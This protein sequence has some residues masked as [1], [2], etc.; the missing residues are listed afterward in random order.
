M[1]A[2][3]VISTHLGGAEKSLLDLLDGLKHQD[4]KILA[5]VPK[6]QGPLITRLNELGVRHVVLNLPSWYLKVSRKKMIYTL[7][8]CPFLFLY[9]IFY[10]VKIH[11]LCKKET[12]T[13]VHTT[14]LKYHLLF[15]LYGRLN[16]SVHIIIH[17][18]DIVKNSLLRR[19][20][21][22]FA[23]A[24]NIHFISNSS[25]TAKSL[26]PCP[27]RVIYNGFP[28]LEAKPKGSQLKAHLHIPEQDYLIG[29]VGVIARWKGQREF[30]L[31]A[32]SLLEKR[33]DLYFLVVG[34]EIYDTAGE[35]GELSLLKDMVKEAGIEGAFRFM[36]FQEDITQVYSA[37]DVL[38]HASIAPEPFGRVIVEAMFSRCP[39]TAA[40]LGGPLE[41][42]THD[43]NGL[44]HKS[45]Q[46]GSMIENVEKLL[47]DPSLRERLVEEAYK[48][49]KSFSMESHLKQM[50]IEL[51]I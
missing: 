21:S 45:G 14:G 51:K 18:R 5:I 2:F 1:L 31:M 19:L 50:K 16:K 6:H 12:I 8:L 40:E 26:S 20:F 39:V 32:Q 41:I 33:K 48:K 47:S 13:K 24:S 43:L 42:I 36:D 37:L 17:M 28:L 4:K 10:F 44:L 22:N 29:I 3:A 46:V 7:A 15:G 23:K 49:A 34:S 38:V 11:S 9:S 30:V 25:F 27:S 35:A